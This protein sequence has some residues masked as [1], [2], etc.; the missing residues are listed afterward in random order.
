VKQ[1]L[2]R[3]EMVAEVEVEV[4]VK[5]E[6]VI[7]ESPRSATLSQESSDFSPQK[8]LSSTRQQYEHA[9]PKVES[10]EPTPATYVQ[11]AAAYDYKTQAVSV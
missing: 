5:E 8:V 6:G 10:F 1:E 7:Q 3:E 9:E 2:F 11:E 4:T